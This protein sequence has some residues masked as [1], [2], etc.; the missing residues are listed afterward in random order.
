MAK[1]VSRVMV[2]AVAV[3][4][5]SLVAADA[6]AQCCGGGAAAVY[7]PTTAYYQ[8]T[9][10]YYQPTAY[11]AAYAP[12]YQTYRPMFGGWYPGRFLGRINRAIWG[13]PETYAVAY[14]TTTV[15]AYPAA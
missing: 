6:M 3:S 1:H 4:F 5:A 8:P 2:V 15:A 9:T 11:T 10:A 7:Q 12:T 14:P 13:V